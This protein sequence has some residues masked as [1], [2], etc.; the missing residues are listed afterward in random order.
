MFD[1]IREF[2][3]SGSDELK[4]K[5]SK[6]VETTADSETDTPFTVKALTSED[7]RRKEFIGYMSGQ[8]FEDRPAKCDGD[9]YIWIKADEY[10]QGFLSSRGYTLVKTVIYEDCIGYHCIVDERFYEIYMFAYGKKRK[11]L[12]DGDYCKK[13]LELP[14]RDI[15]TTLVVELCVKRYKTGK[16]IYYKVGKACEDIIVTPDLW[17]VSNITGK[18]IL[19]NYLGEVKLDCIFRFMYAFNHDDL[20]AYD[21]AVCKVNPSF[22]DINNNGWLFNQG[23]YENLVKIHKEYGDMKIGYIRYDDSCVYQMAPYIEGYG[24]FNFLFN[25]K[26]HICNVRTS[27][28]GDKPPSE[29]IKAMKREEDEKKAKGE[30]Y[31]NVT[32]VR[33]AEFIKTDTREDPALFSN[34]PK[35]VNVIPS[36]AAGNEYFAL[37]LFFDNGECRRYVLTRYNCDEETKKEIEYYEY[38]FTDEIRASAHLEQN[39]VSS[40][41]GYPKRKPYVVFENGFKV[42]AYTCYEKSTPF[43]MPTI[44]DETLYEDDN[45]KVKRI[46]KWDVQAI[47]E[48]GETSLIKTLISGNAFNNGGLSTYV[49]IDGKRLCNLDFDYIDDFHEGLAAVS[50]FGW[51]YGYVDKDMNFVIPLE[52]N[53]ASSFVNGKAKVN[54]DDEDELYDEWCFIDK[55]GCIIDIEKNSNVEEYEEIGDFHEGLCRVSTLKLRLF[56]LAYHSDNDDIAGIWGFVNEEG[57]IVIEPQYIFANDF[58]DGFAIV[59]KGKWTIDKKWDNRCNTGKYWREEEKWG[60]IDKTGKEV[61]PFIFDEIK[62]FIDT[63]DA[64]IVH[65]GGWQEGHWG[66]IDNRGNWLADPVFEDIDYE[67]QDGLFA[68]Y[69]EDKWSGD[70]VPLGIYDVKQKK[71]IFEPQFT[72]VTFYEDGWIRVEVYDETLGRTVEKLIDRTGKEKF[73]S[74]YSRIYKC[75]DCYEVVI[76]DENGYQ[77]GLVDVNGNIILPCSKGIDLSGLYSCGICYKQKR[78]VFKENGLK[79]IEDFDGNIIIP[80]KYRNIY[81]IENP[82]IR[83]GVG[84]EK[85]ETTGLITRSGQ[86]VLAPVYETIMWTKDRKHILCKGPDGCEV[87]QV[88]R[89]EMSVGI[90][91]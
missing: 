36:L 80:A 39:P 65:Y 53:R 73:P 72:D 19:Q 42:T 4:R 50:V 20:D 71:V 46:W 3:S 49:T 76:D 83:V 60:A 89:K 70:N 21:T 29:F 90:I 18:T 86:E 38:K 56:D 59:C 5:I 84:N 8:H 85:E 66:V 87:L 30:D 22:D 75:K 77:Q 6:T 27:P 41:E 62:Y 14:F 7:L 57:K 40:Y 54:R 88:I 48:D 28:F 37:K 43:S 63:R 35:L 9:E 17:E 1:K 13:F 91:V 55:T 64:F 47:Y 78:Y 82:F 69:K 67:Y 81:D 10:M 15:I 2:V 24:F 26:Y 58:E 45:Y 44:V 16:E 32:I 61:I 51:G 34:Y 74:C 25:D 23:F 79:G 52:F 68:F 12:L 33:L 11:A 31:V